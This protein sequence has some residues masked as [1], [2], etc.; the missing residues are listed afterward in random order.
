MQINKLKTLDLDDDSIKIVNLIESQEYKNV[1]QLIQQYSQ[2]HT[3]I[4]I[5][6]DPAIQGLKF[7]LLI[8]ENTINHLSDEKM[9][10]E[11]RIN[12][13]NSEYMVQLGELIKEILKLKASDNSLNSQQQ[14][15]SNEQYQSFKKEQNDQLSELSHHLTS[16]E[17]KLLKTAYRQAS[18][19]CH[20]DKLSDDLSQQG[21]AIFK[22]LNEAYRKQDINKVNEILSGLQNGKMFN[23]ASDEINDL[24]ILQKRVSALRTKIAAIKKDIASI[25]EN[26]TYQ[27]IQNIEDYDTYL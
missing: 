16:D 23:V 14:K 3:G 13:F 6:E 12:N 20:P 24:D 7:E 19:L 26:E 1:I 25:K 10:L 17:K 5:Y 11:R 4:S 22:S 18:R 2:D 9:E 21:E 15:E 8:L 27:T